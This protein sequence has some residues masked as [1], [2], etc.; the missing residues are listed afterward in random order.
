M[1]KHAGASQCVGAVG[2]DGDRVLVQV[3]DGGRGGAHPGTGHGLAGPADRL[4]AVEGALDLVSPADGADGADG[5]DPAG[6]VG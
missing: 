1:A 5:G 3:R 4:A 2:V 6:G